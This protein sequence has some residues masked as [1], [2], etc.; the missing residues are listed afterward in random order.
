LFLKS[1]FNIRELKLEWSPEGFLE[2]SETCINTSVTVYQHAVALGI[3][4][5]ICFQKFERVGAKHDT[6]GVE[7]A[8]RITKFNRVR[9]EFLNAIKYGT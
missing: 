6:C 8:N 9:V 7:G 1:S 4:L 5:T 3:Y 2:L